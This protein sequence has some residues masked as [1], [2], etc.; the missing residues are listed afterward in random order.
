MHTPGEPVLEINERVF[1]GQDLWVDT[2]VLLQFHE[3]VGALMRSVKA[4][5]MGAVGRIDI[6]QSVYF[7]GGVLAQL[8]D[9][10]AKLVDHVEELKEQ[11]AQ[12][13]F[14]ISDHFYPESQAITLVDETGLAISA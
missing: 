10:K 4:N 5:V 12:Y 13:Q 9:Q 8:N 1:A 3:S 6:G 14:Q 2:N 7:D 11:A